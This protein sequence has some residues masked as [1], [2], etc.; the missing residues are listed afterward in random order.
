M[1]Y[2]VNPE[3][4]LV[5]ATEFMLSRLLCEDNSKTITTY[6]RKITTILAI[7]D[8]SIAILLKRAFLKSIKVIIQYHK[9]YVMKWSNNKF[10][11]QL[12][13]YQEKVRVQLENH[14]NNYTEFN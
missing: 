14:F 4:L 9:C 7:F 8:F 5:N 6:Q 12:R 13:R 1:K 11:D 2:V 3:T 10:I